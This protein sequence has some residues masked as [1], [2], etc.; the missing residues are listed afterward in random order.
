VVF[1]SEQHFRVG[2]TDVDYARILFSGDYYKWAEHAFQ[3]WQTQAGLSW[4][5]M[6]DGHDVGLPSVESRCRYLLPV[7]FEDAFS[8][9]MAVSGLDHRGFTFTF[10]I[11]SESGELAAYGYLVKRFVDMR[12]MR[13]WGEIPPAVYEIFQKLE[14]EQ[15]LLS[16]EQRDARHKSTPVARSRRLEE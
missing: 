8:V 3:T 13:A 10:E 15:E 9:R 14:S 4:T 5:A 12:T 11:L 7:K 16:F 2:F 1:V 6:I